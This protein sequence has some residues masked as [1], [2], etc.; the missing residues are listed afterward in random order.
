MAY[1]TD[2]QVPVDAQ[3]TRVMSFA[4]SGYRAGANAEYHSD[5]I[6]ST[7]LLL[8]WQQQA[9]DDILATPLVYGQGTSTAGVWSYTYNIWNNS[10]PRTHVEEDRVAYALYD[11]NPPTVAGRT[12]LADLLELAP[13]LDGSEVLPVNDQGDY[14]EW[15]SDYKP[16]RIETDLIYRV[17]SPGIASVQRSVEPV[18]T[19]LQAIPFFGVDAEPRPWPTPDEG[20]TVSEVTA[21]PTETTDNPVQTIITD[22]EPGQ[23]GVS[24]IGWAPVHLPDSTYH[25]VNVT[26]QGSEY[27]ESGWMT[28]EVPRFRYRLLEGL[29]TP[30]VRR[31][32][33]AVVAGEVRNVIGVSVSREIDTVL[34]SPVAGG[35]G[36]LAGS[37]TLE[38]AEGPTSFTKR[39][40]PWD[41][42][43][44]WPPSAHETLHVEVTV[45]EDTHR[46]F[47]G[48]IDQVRGGPNGPVQVTVRDDTHW[49]DI[50]A[51]YQPLLEHMPP[52]ESGPQRTVGIRPE[53]IVDWI[54]RQGGF[55]STP[56]RESGCVLSVPAQGTLWPEHRT[57]SDKAAVVSAQP[58]FGSDGP[59]W[60][61]SEWG[62][63]WGNVEIEYQPSEPYQSARGG[64]GTQLVVMADETHAGR[65]QFDILVGS[66]STYRLI[67]RDDRTVAYGVNTTSYTW[68]PP[69]GWK[70]L[71]LSIVG[72]EW[73]LR[74]DKGGEQRR[75]LTTPTGNATGLRVS[76]DEDSRLG[77]IQLTHPTGARFQAVQHEPNAT[78][79]VD[80]QMFGGLVA[81]PTVQEDGRALLSKISEALV[82][83]AWVDEYGHFH[84]VHPAVLRNQSPELELTS[85]ADLLDMAWVDPSDAARSSVTLSG[86]HPNIV[87]TGGMNVELT[88]LDSDV[89]FTAN[90]VT[91]TDAG[92]AAIDD[93][94][95][96]IEESAPDIK[97]EGHT[98]IASSDSD[99]YLLARSKERAE[100]VKD[101]M[102]KTKPNARIET[103][104]FGRSRPVVNDPEGDR[105]N[106]RVEIGYRG[107]VE[108]TAKHREYAVTVWQGSGDTLNEDDD[109]ELIISPSGGEDWIMLATPRAITPNS[110]VLRFNMGKGS[111]HGGMTV[112]TSGLER[113]T[114]TAP[115][116]TRMS[117]IGP[118]AWKLGKNVRRL[119]LGSVA[120]ERVP[121]DERIAP[122][123][124]GESL[125]ILRAKAKVDWET[126]SHTS[127]AG[128]SHFPSLE[129][130]VD[131]WVQGESMQKLGDWIADQVADPPALIQDLPI[132]Y[133]R[134]VRLGMVV[135]ITED[136]IYGV[137]LRCLVTG[138]NLSVTDGAADMSVTVRVISVLSTTPDW[139]Q[140]EEISLP[141]REG[142][143]LDGGWPSER[144]RT[145]LDGGAPGDTGDYVLDGGDVG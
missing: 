30:N 28:Y 125:P 20:I 3:H 23:L 72:T 103:E 116:S 26:P 64:V 7:E 57:I 138:L 11:A 87:D 92:K 22:L 54:M 65:A 17:S 114:N 41:R 81:A 21:M 90:E 8:Q 143:I 136:A 50:S 141:D 129:H 117:R 29:E 112:D 93:L 74:T 119:S 94:M 77:S 142:S 49:L 31:E 53:Y 91:L 124:R 59:S 134:D 108:D 9:R 128:A 6:E 34:P 68:T 85:D 96:T 62:W 113:W 44:G 122:S 60:H 84:W 66:S 86:K 73:M 99:E 127:S 120:V 89:I 132:T 2:W 139:P 58:F 79:R 101:Q 109:N 13:H 45:G 16:I 10:Q 126:A 102:L 78:M 97:V 121:D 145:V 98:D 76:A 100:A 19:W 118:A 110:D 61:A 56:P 38:L 111:W 24:F 106:R 82:A 42:S 83:S 75:L 88:T 1:M 133:N 46:V 35:G 40:G 12:S 137:R 69:E 47:T 131:E 115:V 52:V 123:R 36:I 37:A 104:G 144:E 39:R 70:V 48:R 32:A 18:D 67:I 135:D 14:I 107:W 63:C 140:A 5:E 4:G 43:E 15:E 105:R 33:R 95:A 51:G 71:E 130:T 27:P 80:P 25:N 55:Y